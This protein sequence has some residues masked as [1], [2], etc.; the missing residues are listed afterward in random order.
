M[1]HLLDPV[2][3]M[4]RCLNLLK[5][6]GFLLIQTPKY[7]RPMT[8]EQML[9]EKSPFI[10]QLKQEEHLYLFSDPIYSRTFSSFGSRVSVF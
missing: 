3:T 9:S 8:W 5:P 6:D 2:D 1:E 7:P 4:R 10:E